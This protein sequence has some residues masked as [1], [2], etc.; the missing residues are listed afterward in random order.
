M[1]L[2]NSKKK[3][4][5]GAVA[6]VATAGLATGA[7]AY[8]TSTGSGTGSGTAATTSGESVTLHG[9]FPAATLIPGGS[10]TVSFTADNSSATQAIGVGTITAT[11]ITASGTCDASAFHMAPVAENT[12]IAA[13]A[14]AAPL[15]NDGTITMDNTAVNQDNCKGA[16]VT[17]TLAS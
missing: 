5:A 6:L 11:N 10:A 2:F 7:F 12:S 16:T 14:V 17:L 15:P 13:G 1:K 3:L 8:W 4:V 9:S